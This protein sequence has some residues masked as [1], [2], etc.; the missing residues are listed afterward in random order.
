MSWATPRPKPHSHTCKFPFC[1]LK[2]QKKKKNRKKGKKNT[3]RIRY[4]LAKSRTHISHKFPSSLS[5]KVKNPA[6]FRPTS[7]CVTIGTWSQKHT[8]RRMGRPIIDHNIIPSLSNVNHSFILGSAYDGL[9]RQL[10]KLTFQFKLCLL[11]TG[12]Y[13]WCVLLLVK[14]LSFC[15]Y[16]VLYLYIRLQ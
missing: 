13:L 8:N 1:V 9:H 5:I 6:A 15:Q 12:L 11:F 14:G 3:Q 7:H 2:K 16:S 10:K 4:I